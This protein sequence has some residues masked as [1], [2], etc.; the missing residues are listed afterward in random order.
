MDVATAETFKE[1]QRQ[2]NR[3][4]HLMR[5]DGISVPKP[6]WVDARPGPETIKAANVV[7]G[8]GATH[9]DDLAANVDSYILRATSYADMGGAPTKVAEGRPPII[10]R[11]SG[12]DKGTLEKAKVSTAGIGGAI[13][14]PLG[15]IALG[16]GVVLYMR[17]TK[18]GGKKDWFSKNLGF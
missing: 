4:I 10:N 2:L 7:L 5:L 15:L 8:I 9:C 14:S 13:T 12:V 1:F 16:M 18:K 3:A 6:L 11:G 17:S